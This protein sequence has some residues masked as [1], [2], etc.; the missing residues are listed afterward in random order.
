M[1]I[2]ALIGFTGAALCLGLAVATLWLRRRSFRWLFFALG[3]L[4]L[5]AD[6]V[7]GSLTLSALSAEAVLAWQKLELTVLAFLPGTWLVFSLCYARGNYR[8]FLARWRAMLVLAYAIPI[9]ALLVFGKDLIVK[10]AYSE[11]DGDVFVGLGWSGKVLCFTLLVG[12]VFIL[13]NFE[14]TFR[15]AVGV[16]R[17]RIKYFILG[18]ALVFG[19]KLYSSS[20]VL[21][22]SGVHGV[23]VQINSATIL[24]ASVLI[25]YSFARTRLADSEIY[26][27]HQVLRH[28]FT[29]VVAGV[30]LVCLGVLANW[31]AHFG[32]ATGFPLKSL[33]L[34]AG[35]I[36]LA[37]VVLSDRIQQKVK[38]FVSR[39]FR[40]PIHDSRKVWS[41]L[42]ERTG[43]LI[44]STS[45]CRAAV[46][47][48]S[49]T[50]ELLSVTI[51]LAPEHGKGLAF[52]ASTALTEEKA[53][54]MMA[55]GSPGFSEQADVEALLQTARTW[56]G[57]VDIDRCQDK[58]AKLLKELDPDHFQKGGRRV[59]VPL[60]SGGDL[61]GLV[62]VADRVN[63]LPFSVEDLDLLK[64]IGDQVAGGL[65]NIQLSQKLMQNKEMEAFQAMSAFFIHDLKNTTS[66]LSLMLQNLS[67]HFGDPSFR[68][69]CL[70]SLSRGV[71]HLN[72]LIKRLT[73][74]RHELE[75]KKTETDLNA[76]V[77]N[78]INDLDGLKGSSLIKD[79]QPMPRLLADP[80]QLQKVLVNLLLN[81]KEAVNGAGEI[82]VCTAQEKGMALISVADNGCGMTPEFMRRSLFRPFQTTKKTGLGIGM[83]H[84]KAIIEAHQGRI[85]VESTVG[86]GTTF[87]VLLPASGGGKMVRNQ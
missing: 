13:L 53:E 59:C 66:T 20:Q 34:M 19:S 51:W 71:G 14:R 82:R 21:L 6:A 65:R 7:L 28:S 86:E 17:W 23:L 78:T 29:A 30:Y 10:I 4:L 52:G 38:F 43:L 33:L 39:N 27:S 36:G 69:D 70:R 2:N 75:L 15:S 31:V 85:E 68:E 42:T 48:I 76:L 60:V 41:S 63:G 18:A 74:L 61:V 37:V 22:Y 62:T 83:F 46:K 57:P 54:A 80:A 55:G 45:L 16:M 77:S 24:G 40:R 35:I 5:A 79:L 67:A 72:D 64:C 26:P 9:L 84:S 81:A 47:S 12:S 73:L 56:Q 49:E 3:M 8:E 58:G 50:F 11:V 87:R 44:D 32:G 25:A 1:D